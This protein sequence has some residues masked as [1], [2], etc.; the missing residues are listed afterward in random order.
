MGICYGAPSTALSISAFFTPAVVFLINLFTQIFPEN[1][2]CQKIWIQVRS[3]KM[4][5]LIWFQTVCK[6]YQQTTKV[7]TCRE[8]AENSLKNLCNHKK[9]SLLFSCIR[10][11]VQG[12]CMIFDQYNDLYKY[13]RTILNNN[14]FDVIHHFIVVPMYTT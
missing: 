3:N 6:G 2:Q 12:Y 4:L 8:R 11:C 13:D 1:H 10:I 7:A 14:L 5:G 9:S